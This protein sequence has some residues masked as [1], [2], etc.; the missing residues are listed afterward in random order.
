MFNID[1]IG[2]IEN[3][4]QVTLPQAYQQLLL[5]YPF[6][7]DPDPYNW[8]MFGHVKA[9]IGENKS[10]RDKG[11]FGVQWPSNYLIIGSDGFGNLYFLALSRGDDVVYFADHDETS[12][13]DGLFM[14]EETPS[15]AEWIT[16]MKEERAKANA[17]EARHTDKE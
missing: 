16:Q 9:I 15:L 12:E 3:E 14:Y 7:D 6:A 13:Y 10:Y 5:S 17:E 8:E 11:F 4:L 1:S 2:Q